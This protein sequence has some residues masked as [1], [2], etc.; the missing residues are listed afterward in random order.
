MSHRLW[1]FLTK[2]RVRNEYPGVPLATPCWEWLGSRDGKEYG[3]FNAGER[4]QR[5]HRFA[6]ELFGDGTPPELERDH[7]CRNHWCCNPDHVEAVTR[8]VNLDR[9]RQRESA[10]ELCRER[11]K[12]L[13]AQLAAARTHCPQGHEYTPDNVYLS[14]GYRKC[15]TCVK[16]RVN[17]AH[18]RKRGT[19][20]A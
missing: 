7:L 18:A 1:L 6:C 12:T 20:A 17:A 2:V 8:R 16:R 14:D 5:A 10:R 13:S 3:T 11:N 4:T 9:G 15:R 19:D